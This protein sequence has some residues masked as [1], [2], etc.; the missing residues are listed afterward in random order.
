[1]ASK[2]NRSL[3]NGMRCSRMLLVHLVRLGRDRSMSSHFPSCHE[4]QAFAAWCLAIGL[5]SPAY[6]A[7]RSLVLE[8]STIDAQS[9]HRLFRHYCQRVS[10]SP[11]VSLFPR[12]SSRDCAL[13]RYP[14]LFQ[15][16]Y[17]L[18]LHAAAQRHGSAGRPLPP[19]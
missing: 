10:N 6:H 13:S 15:P 16:S 18:L 3:G 8:N 2:A 5:P 11:D 4:L 17:Y 14:T 9:H 1:M 19:R 12:W 7:A